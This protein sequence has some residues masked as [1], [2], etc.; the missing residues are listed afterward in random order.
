MN[1]RT[2]I[3]AAAVFVWMFAIATPLLADDAITYISPGVRFGYNFGEG[4]TIGVKISLGSFYADSFFNITLGTNFPVGN[5]V[6]KPHEKYQFVEL[7]A[8]TFKN[9][10]PLC[11]GGGVGIA[12][13]QIDEQPI[14]APKISLFGGFLAFATMDMVFFKNNEIRDFGLEFVL[15]LPVGLKDNFLE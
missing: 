1:H 10:I 7:Q 8:G 2:C 5:R 9:P 3:F 13:S 14:I 11:L 6:K 4:P 12:F 15:P